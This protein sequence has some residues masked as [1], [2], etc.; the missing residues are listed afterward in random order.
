MN[1]NRDALKIKPR[2]Y[3]DQDLDGNDSRAI[4]KH[5]RKLL[6]EPIESTRELIEF[7]EK[8]SELYDMVE[9]KTLLLS[10]KFLGNTGSVKNIFSIAGYGLRAIL[11]LLKSRK[12]VIAK[13]HDNPHF[14][15]LPKE[16]TQLKRLIPSMVNKKQKLIL[17]AREY[18]KVFLKYTR[19]ISSLRVE[20]DGTRYSLPKAGI[21][22][23]DT[24]RQ[25]REMAWRAMYGALHDNR[26]RFN[27][28]Y[29][30]LLKLRQKKA[31][32]NGFDNCRDFYHDAKKRF[33]YTPDD[34]FKFHDSVEKVIVPFVKELNKKKQDLLGIDDMRPWDKAVEPHGEPLKPFDSTDDLI[35]KMVRV[36]TKVKPKY[37][38][39]LGG[40]QASKFIDPE[41]RKG[42]VPGAMSIP[43][44]DHRAGF[45]I[46]NTVGVE[47]D[48][49]TIAHEG[50][51]SIHWAAA[52]GLPVAFYHDIMLFPMEIA[53]VGSM[54]MPFLIFD[55]L[56]EFYPD[57][58]DAKRAKRQELVSSII[59]FPW[60]MMVDAFQQWV[61]TNPG[62]SA[63][64]RME[65]FGGLVDRFDGATGINYDG[66]ENE[67]QARW[68][69]QTHIFQS[70][71]Y[72]IEYAIAQLAALGIYKNF[73]EIGSKA[74]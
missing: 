66:L 67:K 63:G 23:R 43:L 40:M 73:R 50:G 13:I 39:I 24:D 15:S 32:M 35:S 45:I 46:A 28:A 34:C 42:K 48:I 36:F 3:F 56:D 10:A 60:M 74:I 47:S 29:D 16:Y 17:T 25:K 6:K 70:P 44:A 61:Y 68:L 49:F 41:N 33:D 71:F 20:I 53:E 38:E 52:T 27:K 21:M 30:S 65:Y 11:P 14:E 62:H 55:H 37:G 9:D 7:I 64:E 69:R 4:R 54:A 26:D 18:L 1:E 31:K 8:Y 22:L 72:Y 12:K 51:H 19:K 58:E 5:T 57:V 2:R 59:S